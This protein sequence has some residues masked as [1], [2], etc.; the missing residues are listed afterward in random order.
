MDIALGLL[1]FT[2]A[3]GLRSVRFSTEYYIAFCPTIE[4]LATWY[5]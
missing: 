1:A 3:M 5:E 2:A 4:T